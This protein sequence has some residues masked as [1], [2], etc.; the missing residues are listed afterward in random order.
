MGLSIKSSDRLR[1]N[2]S[3]RQAKKITKMYSDLVKDLDKE[4]SRLNLNQVSGQM[5]KSYL[6]GLKK[7]LCQEIINI[8]KKLEVDIPANMK[9]MADSIVR[10]NEKFFA[11]LGVD[12]S[13]KLSHVP[14]D[15][16]TN[17]LTGS[18]YSG[19]WSFSKAIW[20]DSKKQI[21]DI[22]SIV[23][24]GVAMNKSA[25]DIAKDLEKYV[26][27]KAKKP[28]DWGKVYPGTS[29]KI[30]YNAQRLART[31]VSHA[32]QQSLIATTKN[33]PFVTGIR[34][35]SAHTHRT[36]EL[37]NERDGTLYKPEDLPLDHPN[38]MCT[39]IAETPSL[40]KIADDLADWVEGKP[41]P[42]LDKWATSLGYDITKGE[43]P[44]KAVDKPKVE[45]KETTPPP[46]QNAGF[47]ATPAQR[48]K[49]VNQAIGNIK[50]DIESLG[51]SSAWE[52]LNAHLMSLP[53]DRL[54]W[55]AQG[56]QTCKKVINDGGKGYW[57]H[58]SK[59]MSIDVKGDMRGSRKS[60]FSTFFHEFGHV[61]DSRFEGISGSDDWVDDFGKK[62]Y[63]ALSQDY[64][65]LQGPNRKTSSEVRRELLG[66]DKYTAGIQDIISGLSRGNDQLHWGHSQSYWLEGPIRDQWRN[67]T[68]EAFANMN[69]AYLDPEVEA[70]MEKYFPNAYHL[71]VDKVKRLSE[72]KSEDDF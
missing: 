27:P 52:K 56:N 65:N 72:P 67:V 16:V 61:L 42:A 48:K 24:K 44:A 23:A 57:S 35:R 7:D 47:V 55:L 43:K 2:L 49:W 6:E 63:S 50:R 21:D 54:R 71:F 60:I 22:N 30:D 8:H 31:L 41:N 26:D 29:K 5:Q 15:V 39:Y 1:Y 17:I 9:D 10:D 34:W 25:Y 36:C 3:Q 11:Q 28:W 32:Y 70:E 59:T 18:V 45:K 62:F 13:G 4:I 33:N 58:F 46:V 19:D 40:T 51:G 14:T 69:V 38:G 20:G 37:C 64:S 53:D 12:I 66:R 68:S